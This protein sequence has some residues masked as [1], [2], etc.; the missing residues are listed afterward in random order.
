MRSGVQMEDL[1]L[2]TCEH[3]FFTVTEGK[4]V[5]MDTDEEKFAGQVGKLKQ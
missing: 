4:R 2:N 1:S 5:R 3:F